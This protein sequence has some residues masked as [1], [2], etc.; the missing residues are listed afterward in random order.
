MTRTLTVRLD[1]QTLANLD[2]LAH[3]TQ[4]SKAFLAGHAIAEF[5]SNQLWQV[6]ALE[7]AREQVR[8]G[9]VV[10][11]DEVLQWLDTWG[12]DHELPPPY[13]GQRDSTAER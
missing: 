13:S 4:R 5:V 8:A 9:Q 11:S 10:S 6:A 12:T 3:S 1:E 2:R 7:E